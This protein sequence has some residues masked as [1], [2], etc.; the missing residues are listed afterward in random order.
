MP[1]PF[2]G[3][4][5][6]LEYH[7]GD[8]HTRFVTYAADQLQPQL[9]FDL[10]ARVEERIAVEGPDEDRQ[11]IPDV[12]V[13]ERRLAID[14]EP[15]SAS[16]V[17]VMEPIIVRVPD[18][19]VTE[20]YLQIREYRG[21]PVITVIELLSPTNKSSGRKR[22]EQKRAELRETGISLV[23]IDLIR[24]GREPWYAEAGWID[25]EA[26]YHVIVRQGWEPFEFRFYP[27][28]LREP[29]G[30]FHVPLRDG[31]PPAVLQLQPLMDACY[32]RGT[33]Q[34]IDY[35]EQPPGDWDEDD[36]NWMKALLKA[37]GKRTFD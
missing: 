9:P 32:D 22:Y 13:V 37:K 12:R 16:G 15:E 31:E 30:A 23:E 21:G 14:Q 10:R 29:L 24:Q 3:M 1:S 17:A 25:D 2:P 34:D 26:P 5:P 27:L 6:W 8:V 18:E 36:L 20:R 28:K 35:G 4:D 19:P 33:Y 7:W 11:I